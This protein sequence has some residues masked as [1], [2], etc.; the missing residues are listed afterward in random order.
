MK[1]SVAI[2]LS[3]LA[4]DV[5]AQALDYGKLL[6]DVTYRDRASDTAY[7]IDSEKYTYNGTTPC[8]ET[9]VKISTPNIM[10]DVR[11]TIMIG[12]GFVWVNGTDGF[13]LIP[14]AKTAE[15]AKGWQNAIESEVRLVLDSGGVML[16]QRTGKEVR[17][18]TYFL[19][20]SIATD[21]ACKSGSG[22]FPPRRI[23]LIS[24]DV[25]ALKR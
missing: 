2:L 17:Y 12:R 25:F 21:A 18:Q 1:F 13:G 3:A 15:E 11:R 7:Y 4:I 6:T 24:G 20:S 14:P 19:C 23:D 8:C 10:S 22:P 16:D 9:P 5:S